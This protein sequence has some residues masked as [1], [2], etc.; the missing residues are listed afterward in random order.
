MLKSKIEKIK[1][2]DSNGVGVSNGNFVGLPFDYN[3]SDTIVIPV[4]WDVTVSYNDGTHSGPGDMLSASLQIDL[5]DNDVKDAWKFGIF[6]LPIDKDITKS[7]KKLRKKA[8]KYIHFL[9]EGGKLSEDEEMQNIL[10]QVNHACELLHQ[11][12]YNQAKEILKRKKIPC[13][14]GGDHSTPYG[15]I[16]ALAEH[17]KEIGILQVDAHCDLR[18]AYEGFT[19]SHASIMYNATQLKGVK[20]LVQVGIRDYCE[21]ELTY[22]KSSKNLV[23]TFFDSELKENAYSGMQ[24]KKQC[25][26]IVKKLPNLVYISFDIDGLDPKLCPG[27]GTPVAGGLEYAQAVMLIKE[28]WKS[29]RKIIGFDLNEVSTKIGGEWNANVGSRLFYKMANICRASQT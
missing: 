19:Y 8:R 27:T 2:F 23:E 25:E 16:R 7:N 22:I 4:P 20:K 9:E 3:E 28:I 26:L 24:W 12:V 13:V 5:Y 11:D 17:Y 15:L 10:N 6:M 14:M 29:G 1:K 21:D 18:N